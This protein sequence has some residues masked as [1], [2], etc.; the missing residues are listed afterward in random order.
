MQCS[1]VISE[2][3]A[4]QTGLPQGR[5]NLMSGVFT[6]CK[7]WF[8]KEKEGATQKTEKT[9]DRRHLF[10]GNRDGFLSTDFGLREFKEFVSRAYQEFKG[11]FAPRHE[12]RPKLVQGLDGVYSLKRL[13]ESIA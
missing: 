11:Y 4:W 8:E 12:K 9:G 6:I 5:E 1:M 3:E 10:D 13:S 7:K 2:E